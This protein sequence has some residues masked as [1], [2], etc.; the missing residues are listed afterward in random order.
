MAVS[1]VR[2]KA[3]GLLAF[4]TRF[5]S[6]FTGLLF[7]VI[8]ARKLSVNYFGA[9][10][11]VMKILSYLCLPAS[12]ISFWASRDAAR[13]EKPLSTLLVTSSAMILFLTLVY[14]LASRFLANLVNFEEWV[15]LTGFMLLPTIYLLNT[16]EGLA[17]AT[18]P[19]VRY[20]AFIAFE[21][22]K[23]VIGYLL[24]VYFGM[25][26]VG[27]FLTLLLSQLIQVLLLLHFLKTFFGSIHLKDA[28]KWFKGFAI[29]TLGMIS[30][31]ISG[32]DMML[33]PLIYGSLI[34]AAYWYASLAFATLLSY[35][36]S[37]G[38]AL[39]P[40]L[41]ATGNEEDVRIT[42]RL[43]FLVGLPMLLGGLT[44]RQDAL[45]LLRKEYVQVASTLVLL[46]FSYWLSG[47][48]S[49]FGCAITGLEKVDVG[50]SIGIIG[51]VKSRLFRYT[52][53]LTI[54]NLSYIVMVA[55]LS[56][57]ARINAMDS[58]GLTFLWAMAHLMSTLI[59][60]VVD[61]RY[62]KWKIEPLNVFSLTS[63]YS[64]AS[65]TMAMLV[66]FVLRIYPSSDVA[67]IQGIRML[68]GVIAGVVIYFG[69]LYFIDK[70]AHTLVN[71]V[72]SRIFGGDYVKS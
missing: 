46:M 10:A 38:E 41:L 37:F 47:F 7:S 11:Y 67:L 2:L 15:F 53:M 29:P 5:G 54:N 1:H 16:L 61:L 33:G 13:N 36:G 43:S 6:V 18:K 17:G 45:T 69:I 57:Y 39:Y 42:L 44:I 14:I 21:L 72:L 28:I 19:Q 66:Y 52:S 27:A 56:Y 30:S 3:V 32:M 40:R 20:L 64:A 48:H 65:A 9:W 34:P 4:L 24:M 58:I 60:I 63:K 31:I 51:Y 71:R 22:S 62:L 55:V 50:R 49:I 26:I 35:H 70:D 59:A 23:V 12:L 8:V 25:G 68:L